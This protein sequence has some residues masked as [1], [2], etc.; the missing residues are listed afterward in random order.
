[1]RSIVKNGIVAWIYDEYTHPDG[2]Y[3]N[4]PKVEEIKPIVEVSKPIIE[5]KKKVKNEKN[6][7][8]II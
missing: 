5:I 4:K 7:F 6:K 3:Y 8:N 2:L 1:M